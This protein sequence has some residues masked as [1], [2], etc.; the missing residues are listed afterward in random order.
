M[1]IGLHRLLM[2]TISG[3]TRQQQ[4]NPSTIAQNAVYLIL[5]F[6]CMAFSVLST[7]FAFTNPNVD[8]AMRIADNHY[9]RRRNVSMTEKKPYKIIEIRKETDTQF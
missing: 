9:L 3:Y 1:E 4:Q 5:L 2:H 8:I 6:H 7:F